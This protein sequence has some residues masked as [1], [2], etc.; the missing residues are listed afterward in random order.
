MPFSTTH[1]ALAKALSARGYSVFT[2]VQAAV[3]EPEA[4]GRDLMVSAQTGSGKTV[5]Y[6]LALAPTLLG[7]AER[8][9]RAEEPLALVVAPTRELALQV[10]RELEWLFADAGARV[11]TCVG[12]MEIRREAR[13]LQNGA[14]IVVGT[15]GRLRDHIERGNL[16]MQKLAAVV[17]DEAD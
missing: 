8:F 9:G 11:A 14:H 15:P 6:G 16:N 12:G 7:D 2:P 3:L 13:A 5:A 4:Q 1:P 17:L 10:S